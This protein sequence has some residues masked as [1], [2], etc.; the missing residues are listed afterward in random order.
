[1]NLFKKKSLILAYL[2]SGAHILTNGTK[3]NDDVTSL[4]NMNG[5]IFINHK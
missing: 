3:L 5:P 1:M 4:I 2:H